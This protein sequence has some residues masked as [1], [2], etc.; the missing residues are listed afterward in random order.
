MRCPRCGKV[1]AALEL[2]PACLLAA[3]SALGADGCPYELLA[4]IDEDA[5]GTTWLAQPATGTPRHVALKVYGPRDDAGEILARYDRWRPIL[6]GLSH[7][8]IARLVD[9]GVTDEGRLFV[10]SAYVP[11]RPLTA[12]KW[13]AGQRAAIAAHLR[14]AVEAA[15]AA[16]VVHLALTAAKVKVVAAPLLS[17][18]I[19][20]FGS[21]LVVDGAAGSAQDD[22]AALDRILATLARQ[23]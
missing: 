1:Q 7:P 3:A 18:A 23:A 17:V 12:G 15:H 21:R 9:A 14:E 4:P 13:S 11:G 2:C 16:G 22:R 19:F 20:G 5:G 8:G 10:A 6:A